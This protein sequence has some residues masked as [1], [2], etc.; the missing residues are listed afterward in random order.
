M[1][2]ENLSRIGRLHRLS[3]KLESRV[4][5]F[6]LFKK[7]PVHVAP[8]MLLYYM[9]LQQVD[10]LEESPDDIFSY[11][12]DNLVVLDGCR[13]DTYQRLTGDSSTRMSKASMSR[14]Y[15]KKNFSDGDYSD[16]VY[17]TANPFFH[18]SKFKS[19]TGRNPQEVF[20]EVFHTYDTD[21]D[22][23]ESTVLPES[24]F[25]DAQTAENL[26]P[27][28]RK[29]I[30][31]MQPHH[32]FIGFDFVENGFEDIL[33]Q[34]L[35]ISEWDLA[36]RG[37]LEY[38]TVKDAYESNLKAAMPYVKKIADFGGRTMVTA[39]H[40]NLMGENGLYWHP[41]KSK[42]EPLRRVPMTEL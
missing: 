6:P 42:A 14:G 21:W 39:D 15:I 36:M 16:V 40:G 26:F 24:V 7:Y 17:I 35:D 23:E 27:E 10:D 8:G 28:K 22:E 2:P 32:P 11:D 1:Q 33:E 20:H 38:E 5:D 41:P 34:G 13:S 18:K 37:E 9:A 29:I 30:H 4:E 12:W 3:R 19:I 25:R 31:F